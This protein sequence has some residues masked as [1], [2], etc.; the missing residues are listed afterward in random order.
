MTKLRCVCCNKKLS[1]ITFICKC[2][3]IYCLKCKFPETHNCNFNYKKESL[4]ILSNKLKK[5]INKKII[6]IY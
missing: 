6:K 1:L 3:N 4:E 5:V 2:D